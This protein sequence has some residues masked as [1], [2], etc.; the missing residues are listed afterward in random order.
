MH[1]NQFI[2]NKGEEIIF[3]PKSINNYKIELYDKL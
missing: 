1:N 2:K 3:I